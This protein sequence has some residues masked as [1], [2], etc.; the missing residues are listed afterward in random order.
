MSKEES[1][2][3]IKESAN[4]LVRGVIEKH[5]LKKVYEPKESQTWTNIIA[6]NCVK[7]L[8]ELN[9]NFK[10]MVSSLILQKADCGISM[11]GSCYWDSE[12]DGNIS[13]TWENPTLMCIVTVFAV[14]YN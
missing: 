6:D 4:N 3:T 5:L 11:S 14:N 9:P 1:F 10:Y 7:A 13:I 2:S 8:T 12:L